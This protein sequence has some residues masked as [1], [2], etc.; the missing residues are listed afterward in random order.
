MGRDERMAGLS[1]AYLGP[2]SGLSR[3]Y[4]GMSGWRAFV[5]QPQWPHAELVMALAAPVRFVAARWRSSG[6]VRLSL[7]HHLGVVP[8]AARAVPGG[9]AGRAL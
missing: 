7:G 8:A 4:L 9:V 1:R 3:A 6:G 5:P 2:I